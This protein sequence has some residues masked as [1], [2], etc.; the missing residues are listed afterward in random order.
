MQF[1]SQSFVTLL[2][3]L[4]SLVSLSFAQQYAG[5]NIPNSL[6]AVAGSE[7]AFFKIRDTKNQTATLLNYYSLN[8][9]GGQIDPA[10]V[11]RAVVIIHGLLRDPYLYIA[12]VMQALATVP[13]SSVNKDNVAMIAPYFTN[14]DDKGVAY[15]WTTGLR[16]G[17]GSTSNALVWQG[18]QWASGG[19]NQYP[20]YPV[21]I[22]TVS[23]YDALDQ[24]IQY[25]DDATL[26]P[27]M[28]QIV[29]AGHSLGGQTVQRYA[30][31]GNLLRTRT[32]VSYWTG[33]PDSYAWFSTDRPLD[34]SACATYDNWRDGFS[35]YNNRYGA[36]LVAQGRAAAL[37][38]YSSRRITYGRGT[39]DFGDASS[40]CGPS[41]TGNNRGERFYN[42]IKQFPISCTNPTT[43][44]GAC[45]TVDYVNVTHDAYGMMSSPAGQARLFLDNFNGDGS[46]AYNFGYPR[47]QSGDDQ[48]PNP[49]IAPTAR[50]WTAD[51]YPGNM[52]YQGCF[53]NINA[54]TL[55]Y[56]AYRGNGSNTIAGCTS[57][58]LGLGYSTAGLSWGYDCF[59]GNAVSSKAIQTADG[60]CTNTCSGNP[61]DYCGG[62]D[63]LAIYN[64]TLTPSTNTTSPANLTCINNASNGTI[65]QASNGGTY[66]ILCSLDSFGGDISGAASPDLA[67]CVDTCDRTTDCIDVSYTGGTCWLK[68]QLS[69]FYRNTAVVSAKKVSLSCANGAGDGTIVT[70]SNGGNYEILC[71]KDSFGGDISGAPSP[72]LLACLN[73]CDQTPQCIDVSYTGGNCWLKSSL[74][75]FYANNAVISGR[76]LTSSPSTPPPSSNSSLTCV[77]NASDGTTYKA[78]TGGSY[79]IRCQTDH[80]GGDIGSRTTGNLAGCVDA[81][82]ATSGCIDVSY[83]GGTAPNCWLKGAPLAAAYTN[84]NVATAEKVLA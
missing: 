23:S 44:G 62:D 13:D 84:A 56:T 52:A 39:R 37:A 30:A 6:P 68:R 70:A 73:T 24:I 1:S 63:V 45:A 28:K 10:N 64:S 16:A 31:V 29:I 81:C 40:G 67:T 77:N 54:T 3:G 21:N 58:C 53:T 25:F 2:F 75:T 74:S 57:T 14:G 60:A 7:L 79:T 19:D 61:D 4:L 8:S 59:C 17:R 76:K 46:F 35:N 50:K 9:N 69:S 12:N 72:S 26:F 83:V 65:Y 27:N 34:K 18:S 43:P 82:D 15:P 42:F 71:S 11:K 5:E 22:T 38:R 33:N 48:Y 66:Q 80:F 20:A 51:V 78:A 36:D 41:T 49:A 55:A 32:P 47:L